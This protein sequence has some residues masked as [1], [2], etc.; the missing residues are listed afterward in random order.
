MP[1]PNLLAK[2]IISYY[3]E[4]RRA[5]DDFMKKQPLNHPKYVGEQFGWFLADQFARLPGSRDVWGV[6]ELARNTFSELDEETA[7]AVGEHLIAKYQGLE[8]GRKKK[9]HS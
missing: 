6:L 9:N 5:F 7:T 8:T 4:D 1:D 2:R 3:N